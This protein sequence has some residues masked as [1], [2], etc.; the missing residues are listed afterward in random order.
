MNLPSLDSIK[1]LITFKTALFLLLLLV[2]ALLFN[3]FIIQKQPKE[4]PPEINP[5]FGELLEPLPTLPPI[6][7]TAPRS[8][9]INLPQ[10]L[11][12]PETASVYKQT[13]VSVDETRANQIAKALG[14][15]SQPQQLKTTI[16]F[17]QETKFLSINLKVGEIS[18]SEPLPEYLT[19][20]DQPLLED[21]SLLLIKQIFPDNQ[22][23]EN[24]IFKTDYF[25]S[26]KPQEL[27][28]SSAENAELAILEIFPTINGIKVVGPRDV[29][30]GN[31][32]ATIK[33]FKENGF[34]SLTSSLPNVSFSQVGTYPLKSLS[35]AQQEIIS[36]N[37]QYISITPEKTPNVQ[38]GK[39]GERLIPINANYTNVELAY[40]YNV[41]PNY[42]LQPTYLFTGNTTLTNRQ[43][44]NIKAALPA[45][46]PQFLQQ[47]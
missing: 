27:I 42:F 23:W 15:T 36:G 45:I 21:Y 22:I 12:I 16:S 37:A 13:A 47:P 4:L 19:S 11:T 39:W 26:Q 43:P 29:F 40:Y 31:G 34:I 41:D 5:I 3:I 20:L 14:I 18:Y 6:P 38:I 46:D 1:R 28:F 8:S 2:I 10:D 35:L 9:T 30:G 33:F 44:A 32:M 7:R 25:T 24:P 17:Q